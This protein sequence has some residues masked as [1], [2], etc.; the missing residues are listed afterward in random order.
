M[1]FILAVVERGKHVRRGREKE[2]AF[3]D[4]QRQALLN[5]QERGAGSGFPRQQTQEASSCAP[6]RKWGLRLL[7]L[8]PGLLGTEGRRAG[9]LD[10]LVLGE[11][12]A[13]GW[14]PRVLDS[15]FEGGRCWEPELTREQ[16]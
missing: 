11:E 4:P 7:G 8:K 14:T 16:K 6:A 1:G 12:D 2:K 9:D 3:W 5:I 15:G 13:G 10:S